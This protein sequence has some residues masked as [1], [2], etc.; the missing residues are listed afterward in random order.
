MNLSLAR[1]LPLGVGCLLVACGGD[2]TGKRA[3]ADGGA[4]AVLCDTDFTRV[5]GAARVSLRDDVMPVFGLSCVTNSCHLGAP[6]TSA[7]HLYLGVRC[8]YDPGSLQCVFPDAP[9]ADPGKP[10]PLPQS[11]VDAVHE[12]LLAPSV[13]APAVWRVTPGD[14]GASF[15]VDKLAGT[16]NDRGYDCARAAQGDPREGPCGAAMPLGG[17]TL[18]LAGERGRKRFDTV[19]AWIAQGAPNN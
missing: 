9:D 13:T 11:I 18:C 10:Q 8:K 16:H 19:V 7:A 17:G 2:G 12:A 14:P 15:L 5:Q 1:R 4:E 6:A 3:A